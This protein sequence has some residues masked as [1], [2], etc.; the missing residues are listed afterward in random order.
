[1]R[2]TVFGILISMVV[3]GLSLAALFNEIFAFLLGL[4]GLPFVIIYGIPVSIMAHK[5]TNG[6]NHYGGLKRLL[7][8]IVM[9]GWLPALV[10]VVVLLTQGLYD[11]G[12]IAIIVISMIFAFGFWL[13]EE[14]FERT[15]L[16]EWTQ[17]DLAKV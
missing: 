15:K 16:K 3:G 12:W 2:R 1:M 13:G 6:D 5:L 7:V 4:Y 11:V 17:P 9:G 10:G 8:Y 14:F